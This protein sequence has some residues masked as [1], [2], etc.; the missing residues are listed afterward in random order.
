[1]GDGGRAAGYERA[2]LPVAQTV[3]DDDGSGMALEGGDNERS[4]NRHGG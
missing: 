3:S 2:D 4:R 1:M